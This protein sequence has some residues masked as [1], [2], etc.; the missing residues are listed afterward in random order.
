[1]TSDDEEYIDGFIGDLGI[2][3]DNIKYWIK[4]KDNY[5]SDDQVL[6]NVGD[7]QQTYITDIKDKYFTNEK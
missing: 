4:V 2:K 3:D 7:D 1:M 5:L 6:I